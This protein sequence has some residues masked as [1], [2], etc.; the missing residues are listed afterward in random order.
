MNVFTVVVAGSIVGSLAY[1]AHQGRPVSAQPDGA[2]VHSSNHEGLVLGQR[3]KGHAM[4]ALGGGGECTIGEPLNWFTNVHVLPECAVH[5]WRY[6]R[7]DSGVLSDDVD[8]N[9]RKDTLAI[10]RYVN[11]QDGILG[12]RVAEDLALTP[13]SGNADWACCI[14]THALFLVSTHFEG[15]TTS[16]SL[17]PVME[18]S[19]LQ[20]AMCQVA[21]CSSLENNSIFPVDLTDMDGD[22]DLDLVVRLGWWDPT[23]DNWQYRV[24]WIENTV[25]ANP[26]LAADINRDGVVDGK[27]LAAV[28]A[29]W[30]P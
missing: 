12:Y 10:M 22:G 6:S 8:G 15:S 25:K 30:T 5:V 2:A 11:D 14:G 1:A 16:V 18:G 17:V 24:V 3:P 20:A 13:S 27:D 21:D 28:L 4:A 9:G 23:N 26:P 29:A 19:V 7:F